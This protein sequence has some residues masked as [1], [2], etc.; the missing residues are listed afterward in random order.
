MEHHF[1]ASTRLLSATELSNNRQMVLS[2]SLRYGSESYACWAASLAS[3][4]SDFVLSRW[5]SPFHA[6]ACSGFALTDDRKSAS[7]LDSSLACDA[8][9]GFRLYIHWKY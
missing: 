3:A 1:S 2:T 6:V 7:A 4:N 5:L 9:S 8:G